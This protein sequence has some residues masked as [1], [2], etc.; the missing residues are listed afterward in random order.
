MREGAISKLYEF[1][2]IGTHWWLEILSGQE[3]SQELRADLDDIVNQFD[4]RYSRFR[5][6]SLVAELLRT[7]KVINPPTEMVKMMEFAREMYHA[8]DGV[9]DITIGN[10]LHR[11][12]Y[13]KRK[14]ARQLHVRDFW[15]DV[16]VSDNEIVL[17]EPVMLDFGGFGKGWLIDVLS[18]HLRDFG[19]DA[20]I[21]NGGGDLYCQSETPIEFALE[22][23]TD[24]TKKIGQTQ[25]TSGALAASNTLKRVWQD[26][27]QTK[28]HIID[29]RRDDSSDS[30]VVATYVRAATAC[31][32]DTM[33]TILILRPDLERVLQKQYGLQTILVRNK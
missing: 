27:N 25:I 20:F 15:R 12:G 7:G 19:I 26:G 23:P 14:A 24:S 9:F 17:P 30:D 8:S 16:A 29:P 2:A 22:H 1:D 11:L 4:K 32:A 33:A 10:T 31:I 21:V 28:H 3:F 18:Q 13:G 5:D 6:D